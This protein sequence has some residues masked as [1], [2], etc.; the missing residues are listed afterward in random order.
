LHHRGIAARIVNGY[1][2]GPWIEEGGYWLVSQNQAHSWVEYA[3]PETKTWLVAD[4]TPPGAGRDFGRWRLA[5]KLSHVV[6]AMRFRWDRYV[7]RFSDEEQQKGFAWLQTQAAKIKALIPGKNTLKA[8]IASAALLLLALSAWNYQKW[9]RLLMGGDISPGT[10]LALRPLIRAA[11]LI[12]FPGETIRAWMKRLGESRPDRAEAL[13]QLA[14][15]ID[16][17]VYGQSGAD[18]ALPIKME[19][20]VWRAGAPGQGKRG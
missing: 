5:E 20:K 15:L 10:V 13:V 11:K 18:I 1:R 9:I 7:V 12:P 4:P 19:A 16:G 14:D 17:R 6:D 3:D 8:I 2:L